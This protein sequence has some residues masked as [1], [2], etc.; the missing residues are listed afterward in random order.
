VAKTAP[1]GVVLGRKQSPAGAPR[2]MN[3]MTI[4]RRRMSRQSI[5]GRDGY[6]VLQALAYTIL[7]IEALPEPQQEWSN[8]EQ[9]K[10]LL[11]VWSRGCSED[12]FDNARHHIN[13]DNW[14]VFPA[15]VESNGAKAV[16]SD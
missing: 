6:L 3:T 15:Y 12:F 8:K 9:M 2:K 5:T 16:Q 1:A 13:G 11:K 4:N 14:S 10:E 7:T